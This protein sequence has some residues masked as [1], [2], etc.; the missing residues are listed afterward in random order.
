MN[1]YIEM[2]RE[3][4]GWTKRKMA[5]ELGVTEQTYHGWLNGSEVKEIYVKYVDLL[6]K[7]RNLGGFRDQIKNK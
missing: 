1:D 7:S 2:A 5:K 6:L 4:L 3:S